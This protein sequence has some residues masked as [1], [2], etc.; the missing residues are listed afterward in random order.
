M[1]GLERFVG[2]EELAEEGDA[3]SAVLH[4]HFPF[5]DRKEA[6]RDG[7][8]CL[9]QGGEGLEAGRARAGQGALPLVLVRRAPVEVLA[10]DLTLG[11]GQ[12]E[13]NEIDGRDVVGDADGEHVVGYAVGRHVDP[14]R[15]GAHAAA[16]QVVDLGLG[17]QSP[18]RLDVI[19]ADADGSLQVVVLYV[20]RLEGVHGVVERCGGLQEPVPQAGAD[21]PVR[22]VVVPEE[23]AGAP[24]VAVL[25]LVL[26]PHLPD[27]LRVDGAHHLPAAGKLL[28]ARRL[29]VL[30]YH[31]LVERAHQVEAV[32][33]HV[34]P[35][36]LVHG[37]EVLAGHHLVE[38][39]DDGKGRG[40]VLGVEAVDAAAAVGGGVLVVAHGIDLLVGAAVVHAVTF[41]LHLIGHVGGKAADEFFGARDGCAL[42]ARHIDDDAGMVADALHGALHVGEVERFVHGVLRVAGHPELLPHH[43]A[44]L[45]AQLVEAVALGYAAAPQTQQVDARLVGEGQLGLHPLVVGAEHG[46]GNPVGAAHEGL[47]AVHEEELRL[48]GR[49]A[50]GNDFAYAEA[51]GEAV[52][53]V[54]LAVEQLEAE[55]VEVLPALVLGPP[56]ARPLHDELRVVLRCERHRRV[57]AAAYPYLVLTETDA[58]AFYFPEDGA[59]GAAGARVPDLDAHRLAGLV[60]AGVGKLGADEG[61]AQLLS[62]RGIEAYGAP[63]AGVA[64]AYAVLVGEVPAH[65]HELRHVL[66]YPA[67]AAVVPLAHGSPS[68]RRG[69]AG[70]IDGIDAYGKGGRPSGLHGAVGDVERLAA[71]HACHRAYHVAVHPYLG[72]VVDA[73]RLEPDALALVAG[74]HRELRTEPIGVELA[75]HIGDVGDEVVRQLVR[76]PVVRLGVDLLLHEVCQHRGGHDGLCPAFG[77]VAGHG[78]FPGGGLRLSVANH[79]PG[80]VAAMPEAGV[81]ADVFASVACPCRQRSEEYQKRS[82]KYLF[83]C[84]ILSFFHFPSVPQ[85]TRGMAPGR[86]SRRSSSG[87]RGNS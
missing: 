39:F 50:C 43:D 75:P 73:R 60:V 9:G 6:G 69:R 84:F 53:E 87:G 85:H 72:P 29:A 33:V 38:V 77:L 10:H 54:P 12:L 35:R 19:V 20:H 34:V 82:E 74:R 86:D 32:A 52:R 26:V 78:D 16:L 18:L 58:R 65:G 37:P 62:S 41:A 13:G 8:L 23:Q 7:G 42:V 11:V 40:A 4:R 76:L 51:C 67:V 15:D 61:A 44:Q 5:V 57:L 80:H 59:L 46:F 66:P 28:D 63:D 48:V 36:R 55:G 3:P 1:H 22:A 64:V 2:Q 49:L 14:R 24:A 27:A 81:E 25:E 83:H 21:L 45:V 30:V 71:E 68:L 17:P 47:V 56:Q 70:H 31:I 79:V